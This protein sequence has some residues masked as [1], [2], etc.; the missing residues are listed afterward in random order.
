[1]RTAANGASR[2]APSFM[3]TTT[4]STGSIAKLV[5]RCKSERTSSQ[6]FRHAREGGHPGPTLRT[7]PW[8]PAC[9]GNDGIISQPTKRRA[10]LAGRPSQASAVLQPVAQPH[11]A[12][13]QHLTACQRHRAERGARVGLVFAGIEGVG[14]AP[15]AVHRRADREAD[16]VD[17]AGPEKRAI[18]LAAA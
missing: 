18:R 7:P 1:K 9:R 3:T 2:G 15:R 16:L 4:R 11:R 13:F 8:I 5:P 6:R 12:P 17:Q 10:A 14:P